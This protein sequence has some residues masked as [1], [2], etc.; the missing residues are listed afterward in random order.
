MWLGTRLAGSAHAAKVARG[1]K[2][3]ASHIHV[4]V[5]RPRRAAIRP[6]I[7]IDAMH[8]ITA[9]LAAIML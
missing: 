6:A 2:T 7:S 1:P 8:T 9:M 5:D 3:A 4:L